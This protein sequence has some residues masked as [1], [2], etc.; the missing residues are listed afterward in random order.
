MKPSVDQVRDALSYDHVTGIFLWKKH[1]CSNLV[2]RVAGCLHK[3]TG[4]WFISLFNKK[5][6]GH[7]VAWAHHYSEWPS[8]DL[9]HKDLNKANNAIANLRPS[10]KSNNSA[11][12]LKQSNNTSGYKG[13]FWHAGARKW[14]VQIRVREQLIYGGLFETAM[15][16]AQEYDR[17]AEQH[18]GSHARF[19]LGAAA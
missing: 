18:F 13:V 12:R 15:A 9:D 19:N 17:L 2:G 11:N 5:Y 6:K 10:N 14:M 7:I 3:P 1:R 4:Y 8:F 16:A